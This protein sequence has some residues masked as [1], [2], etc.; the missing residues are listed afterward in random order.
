VSEAWHQLWV[1]PAAVEHVVIGWDETEGPTSSGPDLSF[2][3]IH[4]KELRDI[5][6]TQG[7][8]FYDLDARNSTDV[9]GSPF[10]KFNWCVAGNPNENVLPHEQLLNGQPHN[11]VSI[12]AAAMQ[13]NFY[14]HAFRDQFDYIEL[15][16]LSS[17]HDFP[18][19][20]KG[21]SG[22]GIWYQR[23]VTNDE[24]HYHVQPVLA[25]IACW[26]SAHTSER[27]YK[28]R[29]ITGH[30]WVSIYGQVRKVLAERRKTQ[31]SVGGEAK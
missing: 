9:F 19:C 25:G 22:G 4:D 8:E 7:I 1:K 10:R 14:N 12:N 27:G 21:V 16:L 11:L 23:L 18:A 6:S 30:G 28:V 5:I 3:I 2:I 15:H 26:Q 24:K 29:K 20:Y 13:G 31:E 17:L